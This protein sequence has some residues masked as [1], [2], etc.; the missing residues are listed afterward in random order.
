[1]QQMQ[2]MQQMHDKM[3]NAKTPQ[4]RGKLMAEHMKTMQ[5]GMAIMDGMPSAGMGTMKGSMDSGQ[6]MMEKRMEMMQ[7]MMKMM[8]D[9]IPT[10]PGK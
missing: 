1:M 5:E 10:A 6:P 2:Q 3:M 7:A 8:M 9:R 4:E